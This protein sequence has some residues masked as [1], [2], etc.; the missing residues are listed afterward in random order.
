M[1]STVACYWKSPCNYNL[2]FLDAVYSPILNLMQSL[3]YVK[4]IL[5]ACLEALL[6]SMCSVSGTAFDK[7]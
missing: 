4:E 5:R 7:T 6:K 3:L 2:Y 1:P